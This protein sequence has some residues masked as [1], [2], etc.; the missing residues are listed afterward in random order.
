MGQC[1]EQADKFSCCAVGK[2]LIAGL[3]HFGVVD[4]WQETPKRARY[5]TLIAFSLQ[6]DK[7]TYIQ[8]KTKL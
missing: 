8:L 2:A 3:S 5:S 4:K 6:E 7:Y 1:G